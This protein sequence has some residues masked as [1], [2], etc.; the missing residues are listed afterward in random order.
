MKDT[1]MHERRRHRAFYQLERHET[2]HH[3]EHGQ[4]LSSPTVRDAVVAP[5]VVVSARNCC[6]CL[7][8]VDP[9][10]K[11]HA[12]LE[13]ARFTEEVAISTPKLYLATPSGEL[14]LH[15]HRRAELH[16]QRWFQ[17]KR[18]PHSEMD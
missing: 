1:Y 15:E 17:Y 2:A 4:G 18:I 12:F 16:S 13:E 5:S 6:G 9:F 14:Q 8:A 7:S 10:A 3:H 11:P